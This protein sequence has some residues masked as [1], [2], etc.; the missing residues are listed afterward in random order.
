MTQKT[1]T[2]FLQANASADELLNPFGPE[3]SPDDFEIK[4]QP[5]EEKEIEN[6][7]E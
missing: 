5:E 7:E 2:N 1:L 3:G 4:V 6:D